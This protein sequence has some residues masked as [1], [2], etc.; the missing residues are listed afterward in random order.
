M[1]SSL[2]RRLVFIVILG[3]VL[4]AANQ[5]AHPGS[6]NRKDNRMFQITSS[7]F[8]N[9]GNIPAKF[10]CDG[11][12]I[13]PELSWQSAPAATKSFA[14]VVHD[15]DAPLAGGYT[16]WV[17]YNVPANVGHIAEDA[18]KRAKL[19]QGGVQGEN[20]G[21]RTGYTGPCP[22]SGTHRYYF[23]LYALDQELG[24]PAGLDRAGLEAA[25][26]GHVLAKAELMGRYRRGGRK[27]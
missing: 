27:G 2:H 6:A 21:G 10:T 24:L 12:N 19:P 1:N 14:L 11:D 4:P 7:A 16:H 26:K 22:P 25:I 9:E 3:L 23:H 13:S 18:P 15:P 8:Q 17:L 20:D 5:F